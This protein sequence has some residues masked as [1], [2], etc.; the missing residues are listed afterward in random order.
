MAT[1]RKLIARLEFF[2]EAWLWDDPASINKILETKISPLVEIDDPCRAPVFE[3]LADNCT[4]ETDWATVEDDDDWAG[5][6]Y[7]FTRY[8]VFPVCPGLGVDHLCKAER[9]E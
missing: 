4:K 9:T 8:A 2:I 1:T 5:D 3:F 6:G 7:V